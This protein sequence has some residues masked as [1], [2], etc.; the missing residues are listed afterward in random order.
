MQRSVALKVAQR[1]FG[2]VR[3]RLILDGEHFRALRFFEESLQNANGIMRTHID[4]L[5]HEVEDA[6]QLVGLDQSDQ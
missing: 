1:Q 3:I 2:Q 5:L 6:L 4:A